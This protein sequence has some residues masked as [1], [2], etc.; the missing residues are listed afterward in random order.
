MVGDKE[1]A[2]PTFH[3]CFQGKS[4]ANLVD[5]KAKSFVSQLVA[6]KESQHAA[7]M[8]PHRTHALSDATFVDQPHNDIDVLVW[9]RPG[10]NI[11]N[12]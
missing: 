9:T 12:L 6:Q 1:L 10:S 5:L 3:A 11:S 4:I 2:E 7:F 8:E